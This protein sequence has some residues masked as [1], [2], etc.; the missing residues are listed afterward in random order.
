ML[1]NLESH[2]RLHEET[3]PF[4]CTINNCNRV[5]A[6]I[7]S[8]RRHQVTWHNSKGTESPTEQQLREKILK[9]QQKYKV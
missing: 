2:R 6:S 7:K 9:L 4:K 1:F 5:F 8:L 3:D